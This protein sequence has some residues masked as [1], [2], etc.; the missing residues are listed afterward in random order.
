MTRWMIFTGDGQ[1]NL[2]FPC[3]ALDRAE[4]NHDVFDV[5]RTDTPV[6]AYCSSEVSID[7]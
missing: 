3:H 5:V 1:Y 2:L 7:Q 4:P 6:T